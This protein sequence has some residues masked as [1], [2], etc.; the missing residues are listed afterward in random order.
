[1]RLFLLTSLTMM[2]FAANSLLNRLAVSAGHADPAS[3]A[4]LRVCA[5][6]SVLIALVLLSGKGAGLWRRPPYLGGAGLAVYMLGFSLAYL[7]LDAGLGALILFG[8]VQIAM[9]TITAL[10]GSR[11]GAR[12]VTGA[13]VAFLGLAWVLFPSGGWSTDLPGAVLMVLAGL[14]WAVFTLEGRGVGDPL[15]ATSTSFLIC[16]PCVFLALPLSPVVLTLDTTGILLAILS[17][18]VTSGLG[19]ALWYWLV[20]QLD[21]GVSSTVQLS[22]PIIA[23]VA[24]VILLDEAASLKLV[25][26]GAI[27]IFGIAL[28]LRPPKVA[29]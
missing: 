11:A 21:A 26:G 25:I 6:A 1:M 22:V 10:R 9:F 16:L 24:G 8:T 14:G 2:A 5:G 18:G 27:V 29:A 15:I 20:P 13:F 4:V 19:Y 7:S 28:A 3:F 23:L 12:Q 17:G